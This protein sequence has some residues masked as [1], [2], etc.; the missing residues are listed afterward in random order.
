MGDTGAPSG[1]DEVQRFPVAGRFAVWVY[2]GAR[3][4]Y[5]L[6]LEHD[7]VLRCWALP[8]E[9]SALP[10]ERRL[11]LPR[12]DRHGAELDASGGPDQEVWDRGVW[13]IES[14][15][16]EKLVFFLEG[17]RLQGRYTLLRTRSDAWM[18]FKTKAETKVSPA[19]GRGRR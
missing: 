13:R 1:P 15:K 2:P 6:A 19:R 8:K 17:A 16:P 3:L 12:E 14:A 7:G 5:L 10:N 18:L 4:P 11:A 9:P